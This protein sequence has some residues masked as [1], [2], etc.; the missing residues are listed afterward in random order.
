MLNY[1]PAI[2]GVFLFLLWSGGNAAPISMEKTVSGIEFGTLGGHGKNKPLAIMLTTNIHESLGDGYTTLARDLVKQGFLVVS[3]DVPCHGKDVKPREFEGL[4]CWRTRIANGDVSMFE[5]A[6]KSVG[7]V[8]DS[9][10]KAGG[11]I[12]APF[13]LLEFLVGLMWHYGRLRIMKLFGT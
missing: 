4:H 11:L 3:M 2:F 8:I 12:H 1:M 7:D 10:K 13:L 5:R 9:L 6:A